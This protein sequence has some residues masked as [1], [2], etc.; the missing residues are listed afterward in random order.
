LT[1][2]GQ[3][4]EQPGYSG[5]YLAD[6]GNPAYQAKFLS[7]VQAYVQQYGAQGVFVDQ[8]CN[9]FHTLTGGPAPD[10]YPTTA[11]YTAAV[12]SFMTNVAAPLRAAGYYVVAN[13][14]GYIAGAPGADDGSLD[15]QWYQQLAPYVSSVMNEFFEITPDGNNTIRTVGTDDWRKQ[16]VGWAAG[17]TATESAGAD[18]DANDYGPPTDMQ[19]ARFLH[20]S[21]LLYA[22]RAGS[23]WSYVTT[24]GSDPYNA[25]HAL[26]VLGPATSTASQ[27]GPVY[28]ASFQN[29]ALYV[30]PTTSD[31]TTPSGVLVPALDAVVH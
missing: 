1:V 28:T 29:G 12:L 10:Q 5:L 25:L 19:R 11:A 4:I 14:S 13:A 27:I 24:D 17:V 15:A 6:V 21:F 31:Y 7:N 23:T 3:P 16:W 2:S 22:R 9:D 8:V 30:N 26:P 20:G 18:F